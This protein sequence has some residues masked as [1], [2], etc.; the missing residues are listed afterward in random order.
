MWEA[1]G[2]P[3]FPVWIGEEKCVFVLSPPHPSCSWLPG[4]VPLGQRYFVLEDGILH[5]ATTRQDV[6]QVLGLGCVWGDV[7]SRWGES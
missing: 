4:P 1:A 5:Y 6:S 3:W 7:L 2:H